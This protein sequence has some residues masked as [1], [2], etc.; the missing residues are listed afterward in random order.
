MAKRK[1]IFTE[2]N[3]RYGMPVRISL[4]KPKKDSKWERR[5]VK[6]FYR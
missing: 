2:F 3:T 1:N 4:P 5:I 6:E